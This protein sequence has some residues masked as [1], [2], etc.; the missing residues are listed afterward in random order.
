LIKISQEDAHYLIERG[1]I[2]SK[3]GKYP[4]LH[5]TCK[6]KKGKRKGYYVPS[7]LDRHLNNKNRYNKSK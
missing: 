6:Q 1:F 2:K 3:F 4:E 7:Y 5:I